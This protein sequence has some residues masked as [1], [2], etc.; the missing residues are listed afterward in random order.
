MCSTHG[1]WRCC[2]P[3]LC[4]WL[5]SSRNLHDLNTKIGSCGLRQGVTS[6]NKH[7]PDRI[8]AGAITFYP[9]VMAENVTGIVG[10]IPSAAMCPTTVAVVP[11]RQPLE[12]FR[13][14][15]AEHAT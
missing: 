6:A 11:V 5:L 14:G 12:N 13:E 15:A 8:C 10:A 7:G 4:L 1:A 2:L 9:V 3:G